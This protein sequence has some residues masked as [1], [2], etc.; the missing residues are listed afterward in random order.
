MAGNR[1]TIV[2]E[3]PPHVRPELGIDPEYVAAR[4]VGAYNDMADQCDLD[5]VEFIA[6]EWGHQLT[7]PH[8][9]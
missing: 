3:V 8:I 5:P 4:V 1:M 9:T 7:L 6:A 2:I